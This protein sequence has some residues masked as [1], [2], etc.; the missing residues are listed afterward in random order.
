[1]QPMQKTGAINA[2]NVENTKMTVREDLKK[3][4]DELDELEMQ[5]DVLR[6]LEYPLQ[7]KRGDAIQRLLDEEKPFNGTSWT[8]KF[9]YKGVLFLEYDGH[10]FDDEMKEVHELCSTSWHSD[11]KLEE[12]VEIQFDD[13][14]VSLSFKD[15]SKIAE[16]AS[17]HGLVVTANELKERAETLHKELA[18]LEIVKQQLG[19]KF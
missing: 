1:M 19:F 14:V 15:S 11:F 7:V 18:G 17:R 16:V 2:W 13:N 5:Q 12:G 10:R 4:Q 6:A 9:N 8:L 3:V